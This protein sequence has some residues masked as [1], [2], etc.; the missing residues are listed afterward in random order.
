[1]LMNYLLVT[2]E[3]VMEENYETLDEKFSVT[4]KLVVEE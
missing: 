1:M 3:N 2:F 4:V